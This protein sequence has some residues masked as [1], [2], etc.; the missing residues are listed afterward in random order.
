MDEDSLAR[1]FG[2]SKELVESIV[3]ALQGKSN[4]RTTLTNF[5]EAAQMVGHCHYE[6]QT[7]WGKTVIHHQLTHFILNLNFF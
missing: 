2:S 1:K 4:P 7:D 3:E 5:I 6:H